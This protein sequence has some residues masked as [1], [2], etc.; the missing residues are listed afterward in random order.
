M[1]MTVDEELDL[2]R[3]FAHAVLKSIETPFKVAKSLVNSDILAL[4][5]SK[6][7]T[8]DPEVIAEKERLI[9]T[10]GKK[11]FLP[12][13]EELAKELY[14][15]AVE[16]TDFDTKHKFYKLYAETQGMIEK[17]VTNN[18]IAIQNTANR[19]MVIR[20]TGSDDAWEKKLKAQQE[21]LANDN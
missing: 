6:E 8:Q 21:K 10:L 19:I 13:K 1:S 3:K 15:T 2:K 11:H 20:E 7:W 9:R 18:N 14:K 16:A 17:P 12:S 4:R 5:I